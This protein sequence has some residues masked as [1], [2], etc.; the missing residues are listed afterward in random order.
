[1]MLVPF[2]FY[3]ILGLAVPAG[4]DG[5]KLFSPRLSRYVIL[6]R[7]GHAGLPTTVW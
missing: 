7:C 6:I 5:I 3:M 1:M 2:L 4:S